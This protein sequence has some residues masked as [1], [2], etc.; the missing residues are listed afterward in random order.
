MKRKYKLIIKATFMF[1]VII[2]ILTYMILYIINAPAGVVKRGP[3]GHEYY[4]TIESTIHLEGCDHKS[5]KT[6][7]HKEQNI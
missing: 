7:S 5:H 1:A 2:T 4:H 3:D 6:K